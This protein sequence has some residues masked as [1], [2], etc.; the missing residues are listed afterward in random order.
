M[1]IFLE[2]ISRFGYKI[3]NGLYKSQLEQMAKREE[4]YQGNFEKFSTEIDSKNTSMESEKKII[5]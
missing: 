4:K 2:K 3:K 1:K 5:L